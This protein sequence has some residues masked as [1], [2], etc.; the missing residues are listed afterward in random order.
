VA[1][2]VKLYAI[3]KLSLLIAMLPFGEPKPSFNRIFFLETSKSNVEAYWASQPEAIWYQPL[4]VNS[5][6]SISG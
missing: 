2:S 4:L 1:S 6:T 3:F 5:L